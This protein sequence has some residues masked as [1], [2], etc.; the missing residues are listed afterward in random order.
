MA[1]FAG[2]VALAQVPSA[3]EALAIVLVIAASG[4]AYL[5]ARRVV[6]PEV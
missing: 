2:A 1:A 6:P 3:V 5:G 4:G